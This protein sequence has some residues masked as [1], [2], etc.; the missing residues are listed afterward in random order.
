MTVNTIVARIS[1]AREK[2]VQ[3]NSAE[4]WIKEAETR[5]LDRSRGPL[6]EESMVKAL[7][8]TPIGVTGAEIEV[9]EEAKK[10]VLTDIV[11]RTD[12]VEATVG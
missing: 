10:M 5:G 7:I 6:E 1:I 11:M 8:K 4:P 2:E 9:T 3:A 12:L